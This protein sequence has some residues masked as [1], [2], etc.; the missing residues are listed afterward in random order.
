M[1]R[2]TLA[3]VA[4]LAYMLIALDHSTPAAVAREAKQITW[5]IEAHVTMGDFDVV[6]IVEHEVTK[7]FPAV[8]AELRRIE[9]VTKVATCVV[10]HP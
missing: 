6:A 9:G 3:D 1:S 2:R 5:V 7:G 10:V 8:A 4:H